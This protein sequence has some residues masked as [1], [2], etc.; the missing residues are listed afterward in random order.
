MHN[1]ICIL[2]SSPFS[3]VI[4]IPAMLFSY[5]FLVIEISTPNIALSLLFLLYKQVIT[6]SYI[7]PFFCFRECADVKTA[8]RH[9]NCLLISSLLLKDNILAFYTKYIQILYLFILTLAIN[10]LLTSFTFSFIRV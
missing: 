7:S 2:V 4:H 10:I 3:S 9:F 5:F 6:I 1:I 8:I